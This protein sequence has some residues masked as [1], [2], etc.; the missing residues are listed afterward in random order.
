MHVLTLPLDA[1]PQGS[2]VVST[3]SDLSFQGGFTKGWVVTLRRNDIRVQAQ[4]IDIEEADLAYIGQVI[5]LEG[6]LNSPFDTLQ[7]G[8]YLRF[9]EE[10]VFECHQS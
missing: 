1:R 7:I 2:G 4:V 6:Y 10:N 3:E 8:S 5:D 9:R